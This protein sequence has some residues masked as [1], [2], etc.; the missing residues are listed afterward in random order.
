MT[1]FSP[2]DVPATIDTLEKLMV[3][4]FQALSYLY[5]ELTVIEGPGDGPLAVQSDTFP[6]PASVTATPTRR[7]IGRTSFEVEREHLAGGPLWEH[8]LPIGTQTIPDQFKGS[9]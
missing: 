3:W 6:V 9:V 7:H 2:S 8:I 1:A 4:G 5:P